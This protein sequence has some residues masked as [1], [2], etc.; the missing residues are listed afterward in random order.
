MS[1]SDARNCSDVQRLSVYQGHCSRSLRGF[2]GEFFCDDFENV[3][4]VTWIIQK[5]TCNA[6]P[7][8]A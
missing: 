3:S 4:R 6:G 5:V 8:V 2:E 7:G 1:G